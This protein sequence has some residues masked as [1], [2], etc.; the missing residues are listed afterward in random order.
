MS[1]TESKQHVL[2]TGGAGYIGS[3]TVV[4]LIEAGHSG[5][6]LDNLSN[7]SAESLN[8]VERITGH[9]PRLVQGDI[10]D[11]SL[12]DQMLAAEKFDATMHFAGLKAVGES[13]EMPLEYYD[14]NVNGTV[15]LLNALKKLA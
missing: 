14:N 5:V 1:S 4:E 8:R 15:V 12:L 9:R 3:H 11:A 10:R 6:S 13:V 2:V 7:A